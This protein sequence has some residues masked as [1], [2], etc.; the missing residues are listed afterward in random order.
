MF[1]LWNQVCRQ[2]CRLPCYRMTVTPSPQDNSAQTKDPSTTKALGYA[3]SDDGV[4][5]GLSIRFKTVCLSILSE[6]HTLKPVAEQGVD[7]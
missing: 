3:W 4:W 1:P 7:D 2:G 6:R 5:E